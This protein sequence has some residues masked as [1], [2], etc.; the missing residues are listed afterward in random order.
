MNCCR[1]GFVGVPT[2][3]LPKHQQGRCKEFKIEDLTFKIGLSNLEGRY[4]L[5][6]SLFLIQNSN[7][8]Y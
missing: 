6:N 8:E 3:I 5:L 2:L 1:E 7:S 4:L